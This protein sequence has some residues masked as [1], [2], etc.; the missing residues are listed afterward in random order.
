MNQNRTW[1]ACAAIAFVATAHADPLHSVAGGAYWHH[2]SGWMFPEKLGEF[3]RVGVPQDVGGSRD[4]VAFYAREVDGQRIVASVDVF[5]ADSAAD[6]ATLENAKA[7]LL[8]DTSVSVDDLVESTLPL[9]QDGALLA[10]QVIV[11]HGASGN[12]PRALY[13]VSSGEWRVRIV[14]TAAQAVGQIPGG[15]EFVR[16]QRWD[17]LSPGSPHR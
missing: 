14:F 16:E 7:A 3:V 12:L 17:T 13:F 2:D 6:A 15:V 5:P 10:A 11:A 9:R 4:A 1:A 8:R